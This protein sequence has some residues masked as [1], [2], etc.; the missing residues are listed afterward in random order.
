[1]EVIREEAVVSVFKVQVSSPSKFKNTSKWLKKLKQAEFLDKLD[2][3]GREGVAALQTATP[4]RSGATASSWSYEIVQDKNSATIKWTNSNMN[5]GVSIALLI[6]YGHGT[7]TGGYVPAIDYVN[8][9]MKPVF[10][11]IESKIREEVSN[12]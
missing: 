12:L 4:V 2:Q 3:Y 8:P 9:A 10:E 6:Q 11:S 1:M 7:G 5:D